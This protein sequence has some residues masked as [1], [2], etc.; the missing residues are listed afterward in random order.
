ME[1]WKISP[2]IFNLI[3]LKM[4]AIKNSKPTKITNKNNSM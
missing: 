2:E 1:H 3:I 4:Q